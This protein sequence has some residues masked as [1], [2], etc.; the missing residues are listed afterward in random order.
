MTTNLQFTHEGRV[1]TWVGG[2]GGFFS[3]FERGV[4]QGQTRVVAGE[5]YYA[6]YI[7]VFGK[8]WRREVL[9]LPLGDVT[10]ER[11]LTAKARL[12]RT[13]YPDGVPPPLFD[14]RE[15]D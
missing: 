7:S 1:Y 6:Y 13:L 11:I 15:G 9:W 4:A 5:L 2:Y 8:W 14:H 3:S 12:F 10:A